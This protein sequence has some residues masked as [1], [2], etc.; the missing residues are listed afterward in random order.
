MVSMAFILHK[1]FSFHFFRKEC[2][3]ILN[4]FCSLLLLYKY[5]K[6]FLRY[7]GFLYRVAEP[8]GLW[9]ATLYIFSVYYYILRFTCRNAILVSYFNWFEHVSDKTTAFNNRLNAASLR[10]L[11]YARFLRV[12]H[13]KE[14]YRCAPGR[15]SANWPAANF[16]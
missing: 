15:A 3:F 12:A 10:S 6:S 14:K 11:A 5:W 1:L 4:I 13:G 7:S 16:V 9:F 2:L 8:T